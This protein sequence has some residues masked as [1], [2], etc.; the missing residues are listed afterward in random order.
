ME[1]VM[2]MRTCKR[3]G[4]NVFPARDDEGAY[5]FCLQCGAIFYQVRPKRN[6][7]APQPQE[8]PQPNAPR[9]HA[10]LR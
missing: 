4:G 3:C 2:K 1:N 10:G 8:T 7:A 5:V 6:G 9:I